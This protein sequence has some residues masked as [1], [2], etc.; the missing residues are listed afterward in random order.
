MNLMSDQPRVSPVTEASP[1]VAL[2]L[3]WL[4]AILIATGTGWYLHRLARPATPEALQIG[5]PLDI[6]VYV[7]R[8]GQ[9]VTVELD[10]NNSVPAGDPA[11]SED[12]LHIDLSV[13]GSDARVAILSTV[14]PLDKDG[15]WRRIELSGEEHWMYYLPPHDQSISGLVQI[16]KFPMPLTHVERNLDHGVAASLPTI[17]LYQRAGRYVPVFGI[18]EPQH[19]TGIHERAP[20]PL[21]TRPPTQDP[22]RYG[23]PKGD[24]LFWQPASLKSRVVLSNVGYLVQDSSIE[25]NIPTNG[26]LAGGDFVWK[27]AFGLAPQLYARKLGY[28]A[29]RSN[30]DFLAGLSLGLAG[31]ALVE[32][33]NEVAGAGG[34]HRMLAALRRRRREAPGPDRS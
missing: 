34:P 14:E 20:R 9:S 2:T 26:T 21:R 32:L 25:V 22:Q 4:L 28:E 12:D 3:V 7:E 33:I 23:L 16:A 10:V 30:L 15:D 17:G 31:A 18:D 13:A 24:T 8:P 6:Q 1:R 29:S 27:G 11:P 5:S 19:G